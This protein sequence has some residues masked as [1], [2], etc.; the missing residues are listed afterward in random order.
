M[1]SLNATMNNYPVT[2]WK[3]TINDVKKKLF[4][5]QLSLTLNHIHNIIFLI[6][7]ERHLWSLCCSE[8][9]LT[10]IN[11]MVNKMTDETQNLSVV[12]DPSSLRCATSVLLTNQPN[13]PINNE[14]TRLLLCVLP[15]GPATKSIFYCLSRFSPFQQSPCL[16]R[17]SRLW[18]QC[19][20]VSSV[21]GLQQALPIVSTRVSPS[22]CGLTWRYIATN[23]AVLRLH[24]LPSSTPPRA[25]RSFVRFIFWLLCLL[26]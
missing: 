19:P 2:E 17:V 12:C 4:S 3:M 13:Q 11:Q 6:I 21:C 22:P 20:R 14:G 18:T 8:F 7:E 1:M 23:P 24:C 9:V 5:L 16:P 15:H 26:G 10:N 25:I